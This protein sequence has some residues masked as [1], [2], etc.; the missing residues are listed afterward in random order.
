MATK[1]LLTLPSA[2]NEAYRREGVSR[3][4][5]EDR[6]SVAP[7]EQRRPKPPPPIHPTVASPGPSSAV[8]QGPPSQGSA[9]WERGWNK[10]PW[11]RNS[12]RWRSG[13]Y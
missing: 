8:S 7:G 13:K 3:D 9:S 5:N 12:R 6:A 11:E 4:D 1:H 10:Q 2:L